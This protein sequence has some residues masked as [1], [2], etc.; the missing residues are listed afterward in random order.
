MRSRRIALWFALAAAAA[1][2][3]KSVAIG[4][5][6]GLDKSPLEAPL[7]ITGLVTFVVAV[8][9]LGV[10]AT[11][12]V[13]TS[14]R[15]LAGVGAFVVGFASTLALDAAVGAFHASGAER[16]WVWTE[17]NLWVAALAALVIAVVLNRGTPPRSRL[18]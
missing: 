16:H 15:I 7:F 6:G 2:T 18:A 4:L 14:L 9:A 5:A 1:W 13:R 8:V 17:F 11:P 12:G 10:A 3:A